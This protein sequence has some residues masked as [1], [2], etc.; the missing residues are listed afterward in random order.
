[1]GD[2]CRSPV[3]IGADLCRTAPKRLGGL[4]ATNSWGRFR[5]QSPE[6]TWSP[7]H[8]RGVGCRIT[9][10]Q[11]RHVRRT[12][13]AGLVRG[14]KAVPFEDYSDHDPERP[15]A[16]PEGRGEVARA[17]PPP[18]PT[19]VSEGVR[20]TRSTVSWLVGLHRLD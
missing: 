3:P 8:C 14:I 4:S 5:V 13:R 1:M 7:I 6:H 17:H 12:S 15:E 11:P 10:H 16:V 2:L 18:C 19:V 9:T 20:R